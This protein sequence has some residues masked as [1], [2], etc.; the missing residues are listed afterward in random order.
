MAVKKGILT[1]LREVWKFYCHQHSLFQ[2]RVFLKHKLIQFILKFINNSKEVWIC[3]PNNYQKILQ[4]S[5][6]NFSKNY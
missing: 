1:H 6:L 5:A 4:T 2:K 3:D